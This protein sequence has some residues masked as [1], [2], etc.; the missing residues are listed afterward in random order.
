ML[1]QVE[2]VTGMGS[3]EYDLEIESAPQRG[4]LVAWNAPALG[5]PLSRRC[6]EI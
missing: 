2:A 6:P 5:D 4:T 1:R 3:W